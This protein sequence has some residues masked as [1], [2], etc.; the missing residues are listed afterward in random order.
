[1]LQSLVLRINMFMETSFKGMVHLCISKQQETQLSDIQAQIDSVLQQ[2][3]Y[4]VRRLNDE[5]QHQ[6]TEECTK[7]QDLYQSCLDNLAQCFKEII[8]RQH[9]LA[10][11]LT[12]S[13]TIGCSMFLKT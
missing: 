7:L 3:S 6:I 13:T 12:I 11:F 5:D 2:T 10:V 1:M 8:S 4:A 9:L